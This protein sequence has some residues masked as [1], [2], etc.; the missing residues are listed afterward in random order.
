MRT[1]VGI[2][3]AALAVASCVPAEHTGTV[4]TA[5]SSVALAIAGI[6]LA[7]V[8]GR[9][10]RESTGEEWRKKMQDRLDSLYD[11]MDRENEEL[12][13]EVAQLERKLE[14]CIEELQASERENV[15]LVD[16]VRELETEN[17][18]LE[19]RVLELERRQQGVGA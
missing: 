6:V 14:R 19:A 5:G 4:V 18:R 12:R 7:I 2:C 9:Q 17:G 16:R 13:V 1:A 11:R 3:L 8:K 10:S 15:R